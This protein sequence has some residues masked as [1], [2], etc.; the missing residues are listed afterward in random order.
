M[1]LTSHALVDDLNH[2]FLSALHIYFS[3]RKTLQFLIARSIY[4]NGLKPSLFFTKPFE[5]HYKDLPVVLEKAFE[6]DVD[7]FIDFVT[8][9]NF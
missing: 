2:M 4:Q 3:T 5:K 1:F 9:Q 7:E 8:K 6:L